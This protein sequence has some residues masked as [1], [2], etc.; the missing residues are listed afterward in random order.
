M[1]GR[2]AGPSDAPIRI[3]T[4]DDVREEWVR[5]PRHLF[6]H[7]A[8]LASRAIAEGRREAPWPAMT[9][10]DSLG[11]AALLDAWRKEV[12]YATFAEDPGVVRRLPRVLPRGS[13]RATRPSSM[14]AGGTRRCWG[15]GSP[16]A[17]WRGTSS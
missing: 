12:G 11:N 1:P 13:P 15:S 8:E 4:R 7:E 10:A 6:A 17:G 3:A 14:A 9:H 5:D 2:D 16:R